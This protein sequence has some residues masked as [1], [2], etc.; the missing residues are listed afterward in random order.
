MLFVQIAIKCMEKEDVVT[1]YLREKG[2]VI[3][4][5]GMLYVVR[6]LTAM[7]EVCALTA[8]FSS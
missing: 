4:G 6:T 1:H 7:V 3:A 5:N 8:V 2:C